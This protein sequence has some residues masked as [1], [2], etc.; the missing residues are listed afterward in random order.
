MLLIK[1]IDNII[2]HTIRYGTY[3]TGD[4]MSRENNI[5]TTWLE[6]GLKILATKG[7]ASLS[8][9]SL[10]QATGKTKG[11][12]YHHF[13][14]REKYVEQ[15]LEYHEQTAVDEISDIVG[16]EDNPRAQLKRLSNLSFQISRDLELI[17][18]AWALYDPIV[19]TYQDRMDRRRL[20]RIR[21][22]H[23]CSGLKAEMADVLSYRDYSVFLGL[24]Q[25]RHLLNEEELHKVLKA[26]YAGNLPIY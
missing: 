17:I 3:L 2:F 26:V 25:L 11:S 16:R 18:R 15:L 7:P 24:Q 6:E 14:S 13:S 8:V 5:K 10:T 9:E 12:F 1:I 23:I 19:K 21:N 4:Y 20:E 22:L